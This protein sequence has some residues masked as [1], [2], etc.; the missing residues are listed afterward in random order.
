MFH[1]SLLF[2]FQFGG[3]E[4]V[5]W[6]RWGGVARPQQLGNGGRRLR[7]TLTISRDPRSGG[8]GGGWGAVWRLR[9]LLGAEADEGTSSRDRFRAAVRGRGFAAGPAPRPRAG[10]AGSQGNGVQQLQRRGFVQPARR[11]HV[12]GRGGRARSPAIPA[13]AAARQGGEPGRARK[14]RQGLSPRL[15]GDRGW[16]RASATCW[17]CGLGFR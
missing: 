12:H 11:R 9:R 14:A 17:R 4:T 6:H 15:R 3:S 8:G 2:L 5:T 1:L 16:H 13:E 10:A 7:V